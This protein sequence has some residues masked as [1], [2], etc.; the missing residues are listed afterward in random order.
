MSG[1]SYGRRRN[2]ALYA[3][4][5]NDFDIGAPNPFNGGGL[6]EGEQNMA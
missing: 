2:E 5:A 3:L 6:E 1:M 4:R